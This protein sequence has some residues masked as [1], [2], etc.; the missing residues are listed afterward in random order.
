MT[1]RYG[2]PAVW[3]AVALALVVASGVA[4]GQ[5][6]TGN[7]FVKI[8][9]DSGAPLPGTTVQLT[10]I[11]APV[12]SVSNASGEVRFLN[13]SP[14]SYAVASALQGFTKVERTGITVGVGQN[15][16]INITMKL[17]G[18]E[19]KIVVT[20]ESPLLDT[21]KVSTGSTVA[22][23][24]LE[25]IPSSRDP[26]VV[27]QTVPGV[28]VDRVN[29]AGSE[30]GQQT[31]YVGKGTANDQGTWNVDGVNI[32]DMGAL[33]S[34]PQ[35]YDFDA[36]EEMQVTTG[37]SD[38][39]VQTAGVQLNMVTKRGTNDVH[40]SARVFITDNGFQSDNT[41]DELVQQTGGR[42]I[43]NQLEGIQDYGVEVGG[44]IVKDR[45]WLW[46]GY[47]RN[48]ID[49]IT[50]AGYSDKTKLENIN[51]KLNAQ[52]IESNSFTAFYQY[53][54]KVKI[55]RNAGPTRPPETAFNQTGP[56][57][58]YKVE[59]SQIFSA[60]FFA[61]VG[62]SR[63]ISEFAFD[64]T[65]QSQA[66]LDNDGVWHDGFYNYQT[67]RPQTQLTATTNF[68]LR[69][70]DIGHEF[71]LGF[72][73]RDTPVASYS[74]WPEG[75]VGYTG[76][77]YFGDPEAPGLAAFIRDGV[78]SSE[79]T[80][81]S[82]YLS[83]TMTIKNLTVNIGVRYDYQT[84]TNS[85]LF[86]PCCA[87]DRNLWSQ[88]PLTEL[89]VSEV[90]AITYKDFQPRIGLTYALGKDNKTLLRASYAR[91][92]DQ[93]G[94][95]DVT[96]NAISP[97]GPS[98]LYYYWDDANHNTRVDPGEVD[99]DAGIYSG[100]YIDPNNPN[101]TSPLNRTDPNLKSAKTDE[102]LLG[103][104]REV[105]PAFAVG[106]T[107]TYRR[108][109]DLNYTIGL[110]ENGQ[111]L[112]RADYTCST[113]GPYPVPG[114]GNTS[115]PVCYPTN[116]SES[117]LLTNR[118]G[119]YQTYLGFDFT[120]TKRYS[121]KWMA[122]FGFTWSDW[123]QHGIGEG[124]VDPTNLLAGSEDDGGI[125]VSGSGTSSGAKGGV[126]INSSWQATL[127][128]MY[129]MPLDFNISA[130]LYARQGYSAP[131]FR[132]V[133][134][135]GVPS[136]EGTKNVSL[137]TLDDVRLDDVWNLDLGLSKVVKV[138]GMDITLMADCFNVFNDNAILQRQ[139]RVRS[140]ATSANAA[141][142][143]ILEVQVPRIFRFGARLSF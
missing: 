33:G 15:T 95:G 88:V 28:Q 126:Y 6:Q 9:D 5:A 120:A 133:F 129:T 45:L 38:V 143:D 142:N 127:S 62:Y 83:D 76:G 96:W 1:R 17:S 117:R 137:T 60:D 8:L 54:E 91:F 50:T 29:I 112:T 111:P 100:W 56:T 59:D 118:P 101:P 14:G 136:Y 90:E 41:P 125:V 43:S 85:A 58:I 66:Y 110:N 42:A 31:Q 98:Y 73:Y 12:N 37:G 7:L 135:G 19:E 26:W 132:R 141:D 65:G 24:E 3:A 89:N 97:A 69:T 92:A 124:Q 77:G 71:K 35:Y 122:R 74:F 44:P 20:G 84:T 81:Y 53:G 55:G 11:G 86:V 2:T 13:L 131:Y 75:I 64:T 105:L 109:T 87:Y 93:L 67:T 108:I 119:Y 30:S 121:D 10:G 116:A 99:F 140:T 107:G 103:F 80:Y 78:R 70:G 113:I 21:R 115:V 94:G 47:G 32:T 72:T 79:Q 82:G 114:Q 134:A 61:T 102:F 16:S 23:V 22:K 51:F 46:G 48:Q 49:A 63:V 138:S 68:F 27:L 139:L 128:A 39:S 4:Y 130:S 25:N 57:K 40:G 123:T 104:E 36:F 18:V 34:S 106:V 52:P